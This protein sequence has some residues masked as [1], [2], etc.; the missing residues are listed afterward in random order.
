MLSF[1]TDPE[2]DPRL[3]AVYDAEN[4]WGADDD[5]FLALVERQPG[6]RVLD[7]GCGT[8]RLTVAIAGSAG[9]VVGVDPNGTS[10][11]AARAKPHGDRVG[12][13]QGTV[14][15]VRGDATDIA[16][17]TSHVAQVFITDAE[18]S[19]VLTGLKHAL[20]PG[21]TLAFDTRDPRAREWET[22]TAAQTRGQ[23]TLPDGTVVEGWVEVTSVVDDV[24]TFAWHNVFP[25]G[26]DVSGVSSLRFRSEDVVRRTVEAAGFRIRD[27][28]GGWHGDPVGTAGEIVVVAE[29]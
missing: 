13:V 12:W 20:V 2:A 22:W 19:S 15:C 26:T 14:A 3:P 24:V 4:R 23:V 16:V 11:E 21:G 1:M 25:D 10:V 7:L 17:M 9:Q 8:G 6:R 28:F 5:F 29:A 27:V 18:W